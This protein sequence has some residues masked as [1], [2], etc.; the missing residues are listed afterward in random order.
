MNQ[1][2]R[3]ARRAQASKARRKVY[4]SDLLDRVTAV[5]EAGH[6]VARVLTADDMGIK[7]EEAIEVGD[8]HVETPDGKEL[9]G[10]AI[11]V[12]PLFST[13][14]E[15]HY[16]PTSREKE[17]DDHC[18]HVMAKAREAGADVFKWLLARAL[19]D[20]F[21]PAAHAKLLGVPIREVWEQDAGLA[22]R[23]HLLSSGR[24]AGI[25]DEKT[26]L[27]ANE[28]INTAREMIER[29]EVWRAVL[30]VADLLPPVGKIDGKKVARVAVR[31]LK[32]T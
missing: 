5:H 18:A 2:N 9:I 12:G 27:L 7:P 14:I 29:P 23:V 10:A 19:I 17:F 31:A 30:A 25:D 26:D 3:A 8:E 24:L 28:A 6:A 16:R 13:E 1:M 32:A 4:R 21:G 20:V 22:D 15:K 11:C